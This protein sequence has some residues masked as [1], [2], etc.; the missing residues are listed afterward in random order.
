MDALLV[1]IIN[2]A[3]LAGGKIIYPEFLATLGYEERQFLRRAIQKGKADGT[4]KSY[5][6]WD[7]TSKTSTHFLEA[8]TP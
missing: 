3:K 6:Q 8:V 2:T 5:L 7:E 1:K 4:L